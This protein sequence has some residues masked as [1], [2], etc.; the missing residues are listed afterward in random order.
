MKLSRVG[1]GAWAISGNKWSHGWG[2]QD[3]QQSIATIRHAIDSGVNW[4][5]TAAMYGMGHSEEVVAEAV[6]VYSDRDRPYVFTKGGISWRG[7][8]R[9]A[10]FYRVGD[11]TSLREGVEG[12][13]RRLRTDHLDLY[14]MHWPP[15][16]GSTVED[17]WATLLAL[18]DEGKVLH[19]GVSNHSIAQLESAEAL[20]HV[21]SL[22][23][24]FSALQPAVAADGILDWCADRSVG[25][26]VYSPMGSG[27]LTGR[28]D[29][30]RV[31]RLPA[32]DW[33]RTHD[34]FTTRLDANL[35][36][37]DALGRI[38]K[39]RG[40]PQPAVAVAW[41]LGFRGVTGAIVGAREPSQV[42]GWI[43]A[44]GLEL[45]ED[46]YLEVG[47]LVPE[48]RNPVTR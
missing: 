39:R 21:E 28:F 17:Y 24:P 42:D 23:P 3:D 10:Q 35:R 1:F 9:D 48:S 12:S 46:E 16:D 32:D 44:C 15:E 7:S 45:T 26:L 34:D 33:R 22:Q 11:A 2:Q 36:L 5:D 19:V 8:G 20:G 29:S 18:R 41:T 4:I 38:A 47:S 30:A 14:Q 25:V 31:E 37:S 40:V 6:S 13:L 43:Q 27:L